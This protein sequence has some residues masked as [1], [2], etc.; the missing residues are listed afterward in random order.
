MLLSSSMRQLTQREFRWLVLI[1]AFLWVVA[2]IPEW[3]GDPFLS[4][5]VRT[6][7]AWNY[8]EALAPMRFLNAAYWYSQIAF[9]AGL[10]GFA[11]FKAWGRGLL[12]F[13]YS[14]WTLSTFVSGVLVF[15][16][17][18]SGFLAVAGD[19]VLILLTLSYFPPH[20]DYFA[21][22]KPRPAAGSLSSQNNS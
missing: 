18:T 22:I 5:D 14:L 15:P 11:L 21:D 7:L 12:L 2:A 19:I 1:G 17:V 6:L 16:P 13:S 3:L 4:E 8:H 20:S 9:V 10:I